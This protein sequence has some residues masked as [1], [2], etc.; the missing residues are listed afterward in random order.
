MTTDVL[1]SFDTTGS[2]QPCIREVRRRVKEALGKLFSSI[3]DLRIGI[4]SHGDYC[5]GDKAVTMIE[6]TNDQKALETFVEIA[7][8]TNGGDSD[9][10]YEYVLQ[11]AKGYDWQADNRIFML[12]ADA[13]PHEVGYRYGGHRYEIDWQKEARDLSS[14]GVSIYSI[15]ALGSRYSAPFYERLASF[16]NGRKLN[17]NQF[18]D[19][20]ETIISVCYHKVGR[21]D[22]YKDELLAN[23]KMNRNLVNLFRDLGTTVGD[24]RYTKTDSS[25]LIPVDPARFQILH[26]DNESVI[27]NFVENSGAKFRKGRGFYQFTKSE[28]VQ[29]HKEV[30]LRNKLTGDMFTGGEARNF[31]G[32]PFGERGRIRPKFFDDYEVYIQSTSYNRKLMPHTKFLYENDLAL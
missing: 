29:E 20:V 22:E 14:L 13:N 9:E 5:D 17:L 30:I 12:I 6:F 28:I 21:L 7:P 32:L 26:V 27:R 23:F 18:T 31:I 4:I 11:I 25:G 3:P 1:I 2:M 24:T 10:F 8:D 16:S 19:A 15:Q